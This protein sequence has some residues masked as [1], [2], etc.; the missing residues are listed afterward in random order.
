VAIPPDED[1]CTA[2]TKAGTRCKLW[3][4]PELAGQ[5]CG[6]HPLEGKAKGAPKGNKNAEKHG[7]YATDPDRDPADLQTRIADL[8][9][10]IDRLSRYIDVHFD[11]CEPG[12]LKSL[13]S[14]LGQLNSRLG[15]LKR[16]QKTLSGENG[17]DDEI[18]QLMEAALSR[19]WAEV[20]TEADGVPG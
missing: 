15:R 7:A 18:E 17:E 20:D 16:D 8:A 14:L 1:R 19:F 10:K 13:L 3:A 5:R 11:D 2:P 4:R 6:R 12:D 9:A